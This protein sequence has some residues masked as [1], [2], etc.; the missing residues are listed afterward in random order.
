MLMLRF[1]WFL[2]H[3]PIPRVHHL[4][5]YGSAQPDELADF[6]RVPVDTG[7]DQFATVCER[8]MA[9]A[10]DARSALTE[11]SRIRADRI[12][13]FIRDSEAR[14][15]SGPS[16]LEIDEALAHIGPRSLSGA[17]LSIVAAQ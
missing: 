10:A 3:N 6:L 16:E 11:A 1:Q 7:P 5:A 2:S 13:R 4:Y 9:A 17:H 14:G 12:A 8:Q 15:I